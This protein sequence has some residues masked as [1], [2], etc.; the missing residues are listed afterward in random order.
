MDDVEVLAADGSTEHVAD[1]R[2]RTAEWISTLVPGLAG[3][4]AGWLHATAAGTPVDA[5][6]VEVARLLAGHRAP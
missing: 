5:H 1:A 4:L 2:T 3:P 6:A